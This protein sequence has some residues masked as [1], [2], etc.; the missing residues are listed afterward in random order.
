MSNERVC[1]YKIH[2]KLTDYDKKENRDVEFE[3]GLTPEQIDVMINRLTKN[4]I[5]FPCVGDS[6]HHL[7]NAFFGTLRNFLRDNK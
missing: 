3:R 6:P 1:G 2:I 4:L 5:E 7:A